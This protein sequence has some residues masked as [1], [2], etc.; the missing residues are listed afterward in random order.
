MTASIAPQI[1]VDGARQ[2]SAKEAMQRMKAQSCNNPSTVAPRCK[3][4]VFIGLF[5]DGTGNNKQLD[6]DSLP[7]AKRKHSNVVRLFNTYRDSPGS[8]YFRHYIPGV[9]TPFPEIGDTNS[10]EKKL[11]LGSGMAEKGEHRIAWALIQLINSA[12]RYVTSAPL[13]Q[14]GQDKTIVNNMASTTNPA[15]MRRV[16]LRTWQDKLKVALEGKKPEVEQINLS[17]FG[18]SRG[19]AEAR[20]FCNWLFE[21]CTQ[22]RGGWTFAGIP[23]RVQFL[24]IFDTVASV[25]LAN[26][27]ETMPMAGH[28]SWADN[29]L[30][31]HP[32]IERCVHF[33]AGHEVRACFPLDSA[34]VKNVYPANVTEVMYPGAHSDVGGGYAPG[35][36]GVSQ[37]GQDMLS[38]IPG[39]N[40]YKE[41]RL[42]GVPLRSW[43]EL[44]NQV[45]E[46]LTPSEKV[47][48]AFNNFVKEAKAPSAPVESLAKHFM[49]SYFSYR[50]KYRQ[51]LSSRPFYANASSEE[52]GWLNRSQESLIDR[53]RLLGQGDPMAPDFNPKEAAKQ[54]QK[55][56]EAMSKASGIDFTKPEVGMRQLYDVA[57]HIDTKSLGRA[58]EGLYDG[59][60]H[61]SMAGFVHQ[62]D[63]YKLNRIGLARFRT[64]FCG[65]D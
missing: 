26:L 61:D 30:Q 29:N 3:G 65:D 6:H 40:M 32:A 59:Y 63:E 36:L 57:A 10:P 47:V 45:Q 58:L 49:G 53:M 60:V 1:R 11:N 5:F 33:V 37:T 48:S 13:I 4:Q 50:F 2:L 44:E 25:G 41:A 31:I 56:Q 17:V 39:L 23:I 64:V 7:P 38:T 8:G 52:R 16:V 22:D 15:A 21:V 28:Q 46:S 43:A 55:I 27:Y 20:V 24:G 14:P 34:R 18:F 9:G 51:N 54:H 42:S 12:H 35:A 62:L 19:A